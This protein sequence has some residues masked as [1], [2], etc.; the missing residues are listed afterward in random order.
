[1]KLLNVSLAAVS[2]AALALAVSIPAHAQPSAKDPDPTVLRVAL[3]R[4][5]EWSSTLRLP[6]DL[7]VKKSRGGKSLG[8]ETLIDAVS[9]ITRWKN[10]GRSVLGVVTING[11]TRETKGLPV[12]MSDGTVKIRVMQARG[13]RT[14]TLPRSSSSSATYMMCPPPTIALM[15]SMGMTICVPPPP[16]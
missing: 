12:V 10:D 4:T 8:K 2:V 9:T 14:V 6:G 16:P 5:A 13:L 3:P 1:M 11:K 7:T 15:N